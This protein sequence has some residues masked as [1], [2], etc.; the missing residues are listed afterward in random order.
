M[1]KFASLVL[2]MLVAAAAFAQAPQTGAARPEKPIPS[3][4]PG[5]N[6]YEKANAALTKAPKAVF[7]GDSITNGWAKKDPEFFSSNNFAGRGISGQTTAQML[8]RMRADVINLKPKYMVLLAGIN[9]IAMNNGPIEIENVFGNIVSMVEL[10]KV[11]KIKPIL[12]LVFPTTKISWRPSLGDPTEKIVRL[13]GMISD[14][15][16]AHRIPCVEYFADIDKSS[17]CLPTEL[18][19]D[20]VH[21]NLDGYKIMEKEILK[22][23]K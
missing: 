9:D 22:Y 23:L 4:W 14:Y 15:A 13:N 17:G 2:A 21:P 10:A 3:E 12:C 8:V 6:R 1:K 18:S 20:S 19:H 16:K 7:F 11:N 5:F